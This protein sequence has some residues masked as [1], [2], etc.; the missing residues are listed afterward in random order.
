MFCK[1][2]TELKNRFRE[3]GISYRDVSNYLNRR[4]SVVN[5]WMNGF[6]VMPSDCRFKIEKMIAEWPQSKIT[7]QTESNGND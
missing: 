6:S 5:C 7:E 4:Y 2:E 1:P 3:L